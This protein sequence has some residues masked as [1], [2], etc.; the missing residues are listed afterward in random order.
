MRL[1]V[2][3]GLGRPRQA[4]LASWQAKQFIFVN[5]RKNSW[6]I[7]IQKQMY[8]VIY[9]QTKVWQRKTNHLIYFYAFID[10][11]LGVP[12]SHSSIWAADNP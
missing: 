1:H 4:F 10:D 8:V 11:L 3:T 9:I 2:S 5:Q 7:I 6:I 12:L